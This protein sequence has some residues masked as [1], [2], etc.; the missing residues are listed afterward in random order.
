MFPA[1]IYF[2]N[3]YFSYRGDTINFKEPSLMIEILYRLCHEFSIKEIPK[4][5]AEILTYYLY[6]NMY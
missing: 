5:F 1:K 2:E 4:Y 6:T 3:S